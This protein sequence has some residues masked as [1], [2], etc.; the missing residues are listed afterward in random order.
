M[1]FFRHF[2]ISQSSSF[3]LLYAV[4]ILNHMWW[5]ALLRLCAKS[6]FISKFCELCETTY[7]MGWWDDLYIDTHLRQPCR[8]SWWGRG[9]WSSTRTTLATPSCHPAP[10]PL[11][12]KHRQRYLHTRI[13]TPLPPPCKTGKIIA[14]YKISICVTVDLLLNSVSNSLLPR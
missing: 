13:L 4:F 9:L 2:F 7:K 12:L 14:R 3:R 1:F 11:G 8:G 10:R 6:M 5:K